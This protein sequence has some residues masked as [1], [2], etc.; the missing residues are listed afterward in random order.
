MDER[1]MDEP[2]MD[3]M[4]I[5]DRSVNYMNVQF[6]GFTHFG[7]ISMV[8]I[9]FQNVVLSMSDRYLFLEYGPDPQSLSLSIRNYIRKHKNESNLYS[10]KWTQMRPPHIKCTCTILRQTYIPYMG[11]GTL[12]MLMSSRDVVM[13][14]IPPM[15]IR[16]FYTRDKH[17]VI[18][19]Q[20]QDDFFRN[21]DS[22]NN[23][24][25]FDV[26][27][28]QHDIISQHITKSN[29]RKNKKYRRRNTHV[30]HITRKK[31]KRQKK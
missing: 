23:P 18:F 9:T 8:P 19:T 10:E 1:E 29:T 25:I 27:K 26:L 28:E 6:P 15:W 20:G 5:V 13:T 24:I 16:A 31:Q 7:K 3:K 22:Q 14:V 11:N 4:D 2:E 12:V 17:S 21:T 30:S